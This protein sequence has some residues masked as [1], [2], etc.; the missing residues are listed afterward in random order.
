MKKN[1]SYSL[2]WLHYLSETIYF[3]EAQKLVVYNFSLLLCV[4]STVFHMF[5]ILLWYLLLARNEPSEKYANQCHLSLHH[6]HVSC[7]YKFF[8]ADMN[9]DPRSVYLF[10]FY[11]NI[12][13]RLQAYANSEW[14]RSSLIYL[15]F[16]DFTHIISSKRAKSVII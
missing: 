12:L 13:D 3:L 14:C 7:T 15:L 10:F 16:C 4:V 9:K 1:E 2:I 8:I 5:Y 6:F 11:V